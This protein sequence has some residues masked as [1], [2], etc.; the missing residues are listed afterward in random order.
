MSPAFLL[1]IGLS[2]LGAVALLF[3]ALRGSFQP[4]A[5]K[6]GLKVLENAPQH[7]FNMA[8]IRQGMDPED[9]K[10]AASKGGARLAATLRRERRRY[11]C[12]R[13]IARSDRDAGSGTAVATGSTSN[14]SVT[15]TKGPG[16][17]A[18]P[19]KIPSNP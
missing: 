18:V 9:L 12:A 6:D 14:V 1:A 13:P 10:Y 2:T 3:W 8:Q 17:D 11:R 19:M 5:I 7:L 16:G 4:P 15:G